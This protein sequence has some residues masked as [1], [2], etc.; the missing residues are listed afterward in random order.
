MSKIFTKKNSEGSKLSKFVGAYVPTNLYT[1]LSLYVIANGTSKTDVLKTALDD[2][3]EFETQK[4]QISESQL[5]KDV[6]QYV[7]I[8]KWEEA[9]KSRVKLE[10]FVMQITDEL[11]KQGFDDSVINKILK[12]FTHDTQR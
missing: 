6:V 11:Q 1:Y 2:W 12:V 8:P 3:Y 9:S 7:L 5:T 10:K 4:N